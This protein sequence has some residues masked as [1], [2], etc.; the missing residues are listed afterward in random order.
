MYLIAKARLNYEGWPLAIG[1]ITL[2][3]ILLDEKFEFDGLSF[4][5]LTLMLDYL[6]KSFRLNKEFLR[7]VLVIYGN[8]KAI[9]AVKF[10]RL[11]LNNSEYQ[12]ENAITDLIKSLR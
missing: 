7:R 5:S 9:K 2:E 3:D 12:R 10:C 8:D 4:T 11:L 6:S 1:G